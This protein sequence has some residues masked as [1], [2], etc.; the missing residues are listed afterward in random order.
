MLYLVKK[1]GEEFTIFMEA[2]AIRRI[3]VKLEVVYYQLTVPG[4]YTPATLDELNDIAKEYNLGSIIDN[5]TDITNMSSKVIDKLIIIEKVRDKEVPYLP[6]NIS[7]SAHYREL[8]ESL[9]YLYVYQLK[10]LAWCYGIEDWHKMRH[11]KVKNHVMR[12]IESLQLKFAEP[13]STLQN[14]EKP[15]EV[16]EEPAEYKKQGNYI[17]GFNKNGVCI[18]EYVKV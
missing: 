8:N 15:A 9:D 4:I 10:L 6:I 3:P 12:Y 1:I 7:Y 13:S 11:Q 2:L 5:I 16:E 17:R 14:K 18:V